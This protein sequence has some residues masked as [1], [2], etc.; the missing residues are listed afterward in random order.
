MHLLQPSSNVQVSRKTPD[1]PARAR[2]R[3]DPQGLR[4]SVALQR[5]QRR[6]GAGAAGQDGG[7]R[8]RRGLQ[9]LRRGRRLRQGGLH[10]DRLLQPAQ[11]PRAGAPRR[12]RSAHRTAAR[13]LDRES[14]RADLLVLEALPPPFERQLHHF[15]DVKIEGNQIIERIYARRRCRRPS[16]R[17]SSTTASRSGKDYNAGGARYNNTF[18]QMVGIGTITDSLAR[19]SSRSSTSGKRPDAGRARQDHCSTMTSGIRSR[20]ARRLVTEC[21]STAT[22]TIRGR[23]DGQGL[24]FV[25][26]GGRRSARRPRAATYRIEMLPT[27]CHIYFGAVTGASSRRPHGR[28]PCPRASRRSRAPTVS[29]PTAVLKSAGKMDHIQTGGTLL[30]LKLT[31]ALLAGGRRASRAVPIWCGATSRWTDTTF[32]STS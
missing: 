27:T 11:D 20:C 15:L 31:P 32:S 30:N 1:A 26:R 9:W 18:I 5:R 24:R 19:R 10:P 7:G 13:P 2:P 12:P 4:L 23:P 8:P 25:V 3:G 21:P 28:G 29:G 6:R 22:T 14:G 16:S 17:C